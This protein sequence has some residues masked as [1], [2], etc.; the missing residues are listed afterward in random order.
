M[1]MAYTQIYSKLCYYHEELQ[2]VTYIKVS[3]NFFGFQCQALKKKNKKK[4]Q[5]IIYL[6]KKKKRLILYHGNN[7]KTYYEG[8]T[9]WLG[10]TNLD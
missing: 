7:M 10:T 6:K 2:E 4:K 5:Y 3:L 1:N 9:M 8:N